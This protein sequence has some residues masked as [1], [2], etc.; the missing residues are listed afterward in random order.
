MIGRFRERL[1]LRSLTKS[2]IVALKSNKTIFL[3]LSPRIHP[4]VCMIAKLS[5]IGLN[6]VLVLSPYMS[7]NKLCA[8]EIAIR[9]FRRLICGNSAG[10][11]QIVLAVAIINIGHIR[12][13]SLGFNQNQAY[14][15]S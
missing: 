15:H 4:D 3:L 8:R 11:M 6:P 5:F 14:H 13:F 7:Y 10:M 1:T 2:Q 9:G 12:V